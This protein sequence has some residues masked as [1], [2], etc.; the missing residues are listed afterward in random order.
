MKSKWFEYKEVVL[1]L[2][3]KGTSM[4][5]IEREFGIARSTLSGW[6]K[7]I[8]LTEQ[9]RT[10]L[11]KNSSDG[12]KKAREKSVITKNLQKARRVA[13]AAEEARSVNAELPKNSNSVLE[14]ALSMLYFGEGGKKDTTTIG[15]SDPFMLLFFISALEKLYALD[16]ISFRYDLHLRD[17]QDP[18]TLK[19]FWSTQL[20]V[21]IEKFTYVSKDAR[22]IGKPTWDGY[23]GVCQIFVGNIAIQRRLISLYN[24]YCREIIS[25]D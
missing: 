15:A 7:E 21:P 17:D 23:P 20:N 10:K 11:M 9:Q 18:A 4:T 6:F 19:A 8:E 2:R 3:R 13:M 24:I 16:R 1:E 14:L 22:T 12:W 25:G 5:T